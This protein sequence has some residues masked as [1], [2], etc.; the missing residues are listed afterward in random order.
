MTP[1]FRLFAL[2]K[3]ANDWNNDMDRPDPVHIRVPVDVNYLQGARQ[4]DVAQLSQAVAELQATRD[5][6]NI[7][8]TQVITGLRSM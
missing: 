3:D 1:P 4:R 5:E 2:H 8:L 7:Q 6:A